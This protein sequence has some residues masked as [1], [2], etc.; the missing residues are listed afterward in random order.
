MRTATTVRAISVSVMMSA[1]VTSADRRRPGGRI[2]VEDEHREDADEQNRDRRGRHRIQPRQPGGVG[3]AQRDEDDRWNHGRKSDDGQDRSGTGCHAGGDPQLGPPGS[4]CRKGRLRR[5]RREAVRRP[6]R[7][8]SSRD[9][10]RRPR[11]G[12]RRERRHRPPGT[13]PSIVAARCVFPA[14][15]RPIGPCGT[16]NCRV[17]HGWDLLVRLAA[18]LY[19]R[20]VCLSLKDSLTRSERGRRS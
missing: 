10:D 3:H 20:R 12:R 11:D 16:M 6:R 18:S 13:T 14:R 19:R 15:C 9:R 17:R 5:R 4:A 2:L 7:R 1:R 8:A